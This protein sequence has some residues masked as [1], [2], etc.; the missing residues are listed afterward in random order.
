MATVPL[1]KFHCLTADLANGKH[2]WANDQLKLILSNSAPALGNTTSTDIS[3][4]TPGN[5]YP[6][7]GIPLTTV[8]STQTSGL[9]KLIVAD[10]TL[11]ATG[12][13][14]PWRYAV[15]V[16]SEAAG[17]P[18]IGWYDYGSSITLSNGEGFLFDFDGSNGLISLQLVA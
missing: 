18:L 7:G 11:L 13:I 16:N 3:Q 2:D 12:T 4:I 5:G 15:L 1:N 8:S 14:G 6:S 9:Y 17:T 10:E